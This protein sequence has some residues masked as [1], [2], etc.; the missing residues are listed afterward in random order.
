MLYRSFATQEQIDQEYNPR[1]RFKQTDLYL[2][3]YLSESA[4]I[5]KNL[6]HQNN[7]PYGPSLSET[8][9]YY[10][11]EKRDSPLLC[12]I[13]G[14]YWH[15]FS[16]RDFAFISEAPHSKGFS[17]AHINYA[18]C[19]QVT[20][21]EI[22]RQ[23]RAAIVWL[24]RHA[25]ELCF[26]PELIGVA[27]HSAGGH[28]TAMLLAT[29][30]EKDY[31]LPS[32]LIRFAFPISGLFDLHPFLFSWLQPKLQ[33]NLEQVHRNSPLFLESPNPSRV[34]VIVGAEESKEFYRQSTEYSFHLQQQGFEVDCQS[35]FQKNHFNLL[36]DFLGEGGEVME[37]ISNS[38]NL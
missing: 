8:L 38:M 36:D 30:W 13:H 34:R 23:C 25:K 35:I 11:S 19:P 14:G 4:R 15:S 16:S 1:L 12:F 2:K 29:Q 21:D 28:L 27:G 7:I 6:K 18:L 37:L 32:D 10:P 31:G 5:H 9:D 3:Q 22:V 20:L 26:N 33:L 17:V 24:Y